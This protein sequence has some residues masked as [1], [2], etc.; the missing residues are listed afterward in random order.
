MI[1]VCYS[2]SVCVHLFT[3]ALICSDFTARHY[4]VSRKRVNFGDL[5]LQGAWI[6]FVYF[7]C[8]Q[9]KSM[10]KLCPCLIWRVCL[11][12]LDSAPA[13]QRHQHFHH[14]LPLQSTVPY[15]LNFSRNLLFVQPS[16]RNVVV[17]CPALHLFVVQSFCQ[18]VVFLAEQSHHCLQTEWVIDVQIALLPSLHFCGKLNR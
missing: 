12:Y 15:F 1:H 17:S 9:Y 5:Y 18:N 7:F 11:C 10:R 8:T 16:F 14:C 13:I 2:W 4:T 6:K 3:C